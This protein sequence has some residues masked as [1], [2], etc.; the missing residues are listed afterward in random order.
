M[1]LSSKKGSKYAKSLRNKHKKEISKE[2]EVRNR[3]KKEAIIEQFENSLDIL[4][5]MFWNIIHLKKGARIGMSVSMDLTR[6]TSKLF[7]ERIEKLHGIIASKREILNDKIIDKIGKY[8]DVIAPVD[9]LSSEELLKSE[10]ALNILK[11]FIHKYNRSLS[12]Y[13]HI[14]IALKQLTDIL[15]LEGDYRDPLIVKDMKYLEVLLKLMIILSKPPKG[16]Y[17]LFS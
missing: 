9:L 17:D 3:H 16:I 13:N 15:K 1:E 4:F 12:S 8:F 11:E 10:I 5:T 2:Q 14:A 7:V 6:E